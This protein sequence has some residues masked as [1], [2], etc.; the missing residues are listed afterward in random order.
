MEYE[1]CLEWNYRIAK[2]NGNAHT[3]H[4]I[5]IRTPLAL[6]MRHA[7]LCAVCVTDFDQE[8]VIV[9]E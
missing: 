5:I 3:G 8:V 1:H 6:G 7:L 9:H 2:W 4:A